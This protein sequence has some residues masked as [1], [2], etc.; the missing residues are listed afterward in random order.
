M[1]ARYGGPVGNRSPPPSLQCQPPQRSSTT[2]LASR[3]VSKTSQ[4]SPSRCWCFTALVSW[5]GLPVPTELLKSQ[6]DL[7]IRDVDFDRLASLA[8]PNEPP[9]PL[10][11]VVRTA[12][13]S[14]SSLTSAPITN[15]NRP[16]TAELMARMKL[17]FAEHGGRVKKETLWQDPLLSKA[18]ESER[19]RCLKELADYDRSSRDY[20]LILDERAGGAIEIEICMHNRIV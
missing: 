20:K 5:G 2:I 9:P 12:T 3:S 14:S 11:T 4:C 6:T 8:R 16:T 17:V 10:V 18:L 1:R 19:N 7:A 15:G 13:T